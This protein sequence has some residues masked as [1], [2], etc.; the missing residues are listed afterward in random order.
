MADNAAELAAMFGYEVPD[1]PEE[2]VTPETPETPETKPESGEGEGE[3]SGVAA[4]ETPTGEK[5]PTEPEAEISPD[6]SP[7]DRYDTLLEELKRYRRF[8]PVLEMLEEEPSLARQ[9]LAQRIASGTPAQ[10]PEKPAPTTP[11]DE[12]LKAY[13][14]RR[15]QEDPV[16]GLAEFMD[17]AFEQKIAQR[18]GPT[19]AIT[20]RSAVKDFKTDLKASDPSFVQREAIFDALIEKADKNALKA[21][22]EASLQALEVLAFGIWAKQ[23]REAMVRAAAARKPVA[24]E[25]PRSLGISTSEAPT[26]GKTAKP[27]RE[28]TD[29][30]RHLAIIYP[31][32]VEALEE[33]DNEESPWGSN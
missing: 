15:M 32:L 8:A 25:T 19:E 14:T 3:P 31:D 1:E 2:E 10:E 11:S 18:L 22:P 23:Q 20:Q 24:K 30:E 12:E 6:V 7:A 16:G 29:E 28:L 13:W 33:D 4:P 21:N 9:V 5:A 26:A 17:R 27:K